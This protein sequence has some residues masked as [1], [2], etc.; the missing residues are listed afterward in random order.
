MFLYD[1]AVFAFCVL[2]THFGPQ[3]LEKMSMGRRIVARLVATRIS[4]WAE[5][6][7]LLDDNQAGFRAGRSTADATQIMMRLQ[8]DG[9]DLRKRGGGVG[10]VPS[11]R[12]LDLR[13]AYPRVN[14]AAL[15]MLL[16]RY[17]LNGCFLRLLQDLHECT[18]YVVRGREGNSDPWVPGRGLTEGCPSSPGL[19]N[20]Y[21][22]AV[23]RIAKAERERK[24]A[25]DG[26]V[27][28]IVMKWVPGSAFPS[29]KTWEKKECTEAKAVVVEKSLFADDTTAVGEKEELEV[30]IRITKE[31]MGRF[32]ERNNDNKEEAVDFGG[33][34]SGDI[35]MLGTWLG[36]K[37][38][39]DKRLARA[40]KSWFKLKSRLVGSKMSKRM[41]ARIVETCVESSLLFDCQ[42]RV[43]QVRELNRMQRFMD[44]I[45]RYVWSRKTKPPLIQMQDESK[46]MFDV[47]KELGVMSVRWKVEKRV[48]ERVGHVMRMDDSRLTKVCVLGW[49]EALEDH[50]KAPGKCRKTVLYWKKLMREAGLDPTNVA[51]LTKDRK[52]W[53]QKVKE[54]MDHLRKWEASKGKRWTGE[55]VGRNDMVVDT[56]FDC[57]VC[58]KVCKSKAGLVNHRRRM[59]EES[60]A[61]KKFECVKCR[62][63]FNK[64]SEL[65][66]HGKVCGGAVASSSVRVMCVC[67][68]EYS[69]NYFRKHRGSCAAWQAQRQEEEPAGR[70]AM[71]RVPCPGCGTIMRKDNLSR[72]RGTACPGGEAGP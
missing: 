33:E 41:Q 13:K 68:K 66:N 40:G 29:E 70:P 32:E 26:R 24:A 16:E 19:F 61:K 69:K 36:W 11:A 20:I 28:G 2:T 62:T 5:D 57:R 31:V 12:L 45:Y 42:V 3:N 15:W 54:R 52:V 18:E 14:K 39:I 60:V 63:V 53:K 6:M 56:V 49:M 38:D 55:P 10:F 4:E 47:R 50:G 30:G 37:E 34:G 7:E 71:Q 17:G 43:W 67:G 22:Q 65:K 1:E 35:R 27:A 59:H 72:H 46:N 25:E 44:R 23:M 64:A 51:S 48:L 8:E 9:V 58:G 21:H